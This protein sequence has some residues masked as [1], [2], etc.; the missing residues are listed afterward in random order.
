MRVL[1]VLGVVA[2]CCI[3]YYLFPLIKVIGDSMYATY[4]DNE[5]IVGS[6]VFLKSR[7][8]VGDVIVYKS[9]T[10]DRIVIKRIHHFMC[11]GKDL[12]L[13]C[14]GDNADHSYDSRMYGYVSSK[15][16]VC[17][18]INQRRKIESCM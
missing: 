3:L 17:K 14:L 4:L 11:D 10:D 5:V 9:P 8:K 12:Y 15:S 2:V 18:V 13:Y 1:I 6:R 16:I 7:L